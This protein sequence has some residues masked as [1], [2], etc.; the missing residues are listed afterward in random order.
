V[1]SRI[2]DEENAVGARVIGARAGSLT[3]SPPVKA[4]KAGRTS[5]CAQ[6]RKQGRVT[7]PMRVG[8]VAL[9]W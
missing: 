9:G 7:P 8:S 4:P 3:S 6:A 5:R 2:A 1:Q